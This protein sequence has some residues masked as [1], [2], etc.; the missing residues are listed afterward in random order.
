MPYKFHHCFIITGTKTLFSGCCAGET[1]I[2]KLFDGPPPGVVFKTVIAA[3]PGF[4]TKLA[5]IVAVSFVADTKVV[6]S[7]VLF[8]T[9]LEP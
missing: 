4:A 2:G 8:Q 3:V 1:T 6:V 7:A 9:T 5:G